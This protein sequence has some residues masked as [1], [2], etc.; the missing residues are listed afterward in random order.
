MQ[1]GLQKAVEVPLRAVRLAD[2]CWDAML[3]MAA[4]GNIASRSDLEM[5]AKA[6]ETGIWGAWRNVVINVDQIKDEAFRHYVGDD[7]TYGI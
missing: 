1:A 3:E 5:G 2:T 4:H 6:L 7:V